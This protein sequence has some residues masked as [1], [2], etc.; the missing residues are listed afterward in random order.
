MLC[1][2]PDPENPKEAA[3]TTI[4]TAM[5]KAISK[6]EKYIYISDQFMWYP[7]ILEALFKRLEYI[8]R[9][10]LMTN[11]EE[12]FIVKPFGLEIEEAKQAK[13]YYTSE[14]WSVLDRDNPKISAY[15]MIKEGRPILADSYDNIIYLHW[16]VLIIDDEFAVIGTAGVEQS[17][18]T[19]DIDMNLGIYGKDA[20]TMMRKQLWAEHLNISKDDER[21]EDP[22]NAIDNLFPAE[23]GRLGRV[24]SFWP[25]PADYCD[26]VFQLIFNGFEPCGY[27]DTSRCQPSQ[28]P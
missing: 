14:A 7:P 28:C 18:L 23:A 5:L 25:T 27:I 15:Q 4:L 1:W 20:V 3:K 12:V 24:R 19:N 2:C 21:L 26:N 8:D 11:S 10:V 13:R 22:I 6:A 17:S 16:K 9:L